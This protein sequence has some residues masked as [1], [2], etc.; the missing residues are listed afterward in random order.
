LRFRKKARVKEKRIISRYRLLPLFVFFV[1]P[2]IVFVPVFIVV[3]VVADIMFSVVAH[4][5]PSNKPAG[6]R[7]DMTLLRLASPMTMVFQGPIPCL[8]VQLELKGL[9]KPDS[10]LFYENVFSYC[11]IGWSDGK[12]GEWL[13]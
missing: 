8:E 5:S 6:V 13:R 2:V 10:I 4:V 9:G 1:A 3:A 12:Y 7:E 11:P